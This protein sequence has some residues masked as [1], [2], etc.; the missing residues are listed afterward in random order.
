ME[1]ALSLAVDRKVSNAAL[2]LGFKKQ[3]LIERALLVYLDLMK[4]QIDLN[5][6]FTSLDLLSDEAL[7]N[8][9]EQL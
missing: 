8:F 6:E 2:S 5:K 9:E 1:L 7:I 3:E 4:N